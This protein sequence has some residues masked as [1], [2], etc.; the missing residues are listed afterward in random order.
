MS[1]YFA[2]VPRHHQ[3]TL[4]F[5]PARTGSRFTKDFLG[6]LR[7]MEKMGVWHSAF[8]LIPFLN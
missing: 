7:R 6:Q 3:G 5:L 1:S 8:W 2:W 4:L